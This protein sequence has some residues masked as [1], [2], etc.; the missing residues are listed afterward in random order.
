VRL[1]V[2]AID[3]CILGS[4]VI[5]ARYSLASSFRSDHRMQVLDFS[6]VD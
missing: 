2:Y 1:P 3:L 4:R 6:L 5:P